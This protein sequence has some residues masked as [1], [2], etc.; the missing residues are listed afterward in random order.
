MAGLPA[1]VKFDPTDQELLTHFEA[2]IGIGNEKP[3]PLI[4]IFMLML[5]DEIGICSTHPKNVPSI[6]E[7]G[8]VTHYFYK[9]K[10]GLCNRTAQVSKN[11]KQR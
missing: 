11:H 2:Q 8:S 3:Y 1:G 9:N 10:V 7:D 5:N 6:K 4:D